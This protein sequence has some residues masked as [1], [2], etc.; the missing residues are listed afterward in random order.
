M[1]D[2]DG[3]R[4]AVAP[5]DAVVARFPGVVCLVKAASGS[6]DHVMALLDLCREVSGAAPGRPLARRMA[7]W[8]AGLGE[9]AE[10]HIGTV[11]VT[12]DDGLA[13]VL[14]GDVR[15][16]LPDQGVTMSGTD[17]AA[18]T[19]RLLPRPDGPFRLAFGQGA[20]SV[21]GPFD[22]VAGV[23]PGRGVTLLEANAR[24]IG[25]SHP[26][27]RSPITAA[28]PAPPVVPAPPA[29]PV[30]PV[31]PVV[32]ASEEPTIG[33]SDGPPVP[34][35]PS[36][37]V[38]TAAPLAAPVPTAPAGPGE[39]SIGLQPPH[40]AD[41][42]LG[43]EAAVESRPP[44]AVEP[45][46]GDAAT[47][48]NRDTATPQTRGHLCSRGHLNDPRSHFC[49]LCGIRMNERT[50]VLVLG[51]R[52][53]LGLLVLDTGATFTLDTGCLLGRQ[54]QADERVYSGALRGITIDDRSGGVSRAHAEI[55]LDG[56]D[57]LV[58]DS[59]SSNGTFVADRGSPW[60]RLAPRQPR[61]LEPGMRIRLGE[62]TVLTFESPSGVR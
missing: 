2:F 26:A 4:A 41:R 50:G 55:R 46:P 19:D 36:A 52:P 11:S 15:L 1:T 14:V 54:P 34:A 62:A 32:P 56:W 44:L 20:A 61:R 10:L 60:T 33:S 6:A 51:P 3:L 40:R 5:G 9:I 18:W 16:D 38:P 7:V 8:L 37:P 47:D 17:S 30:V 35:P 27:A 24:P 39:R 59:G 45:R 13:V 23:V 28:P 21:D 12:E 53:P 49:V 42:I 22:L 58:V 25:T 29:P 31:P 43:A 57:V 48:V